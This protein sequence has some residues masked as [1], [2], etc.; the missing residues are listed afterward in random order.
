MKLA[1]MPS[2]IAV[3]TTARMAAFIPGA[4]PPL[5]STPRWVGF[6]TASLPVGTSCHWR[7]VRKLDMRALNYIIRAMNQERFTETA[8]AALAA[9]Q[10]L[11]QTQQNQQLEP[12]HVLAGLL[13]EPAGP[14]ARVIE[15]AGGQPQQIQA[16]LQASINQFP[17]ISG[18]SGQYLGNATNTALSEAE[19]LA[20][21]WGDSFVAA[22]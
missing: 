2:W 11:A 12:A 10:Q 18:S 22:D 20:G 13:A 21:E 1:R 4:S 5:V 17:K 14:A 8:L 16:A 9:A 3:R 7:Q 6:M 15:R 19:R